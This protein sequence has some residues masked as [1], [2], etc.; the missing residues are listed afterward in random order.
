MYFA[1]VDRF[2]DGDGMRV[3]VVDATDGDAAIGPSGQFHGGDLLGLTQKLGYLEEMGVTALWLSAPYDNRDYRGDAINACG[4]RPADGSCDPNFYS[5]YHGYW[6]SPQNEDYSD[7][8]NP[9]PTPMVESRIG[10]DQ[11]LRALV[12]AAHES[13]MKVLDYVMNHIDIESTL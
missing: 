2:F 4:D 1:M 7:P 6:L 12:D 13:G 3:P 11:D 5:P 8:N 9:V 10:T